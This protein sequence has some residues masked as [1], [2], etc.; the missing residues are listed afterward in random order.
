MARDIKLTIGGVEKDLTLIIQN[1]SKLWKVSEVPRTLARG[2][3]TEVT[4]ASLSAD[5]ELIFEQ[6]DWSG[7][8]GQGNYFDSDR[9]SDGQGIDTTQEGYLMLGPLLN[10]VG[11]GAGDTALD[12]NIGG[13]EFFK[14]NLYCYTIQ[15]IY[16]WDKINGY[17]GAAAAT[18][19]GKTISDLHTFAGYMFV[20][21]GSG[22]N[23]RYTADGAD[24][25]NEIVEY[26]NYFIT[27]PSTD[28]QTSILWKAKT[29]NEVSY[30]DTGL[31]ATWSTVDYIGDTS[32]DITG[33]MIIADNLL[34]GKEDNLYHLDSDERAHPLM[35]ELRLAQSSNNFKYHTM[36]QGS[37][38]F[39][40][41]SRVGEITSRNTIDRVGPLAD[42]TELTKKGS[43][44][45]L[46]SDR[47]WIYCIMDEGANDVVIY[48][49]RERTKRGRLVWEWCPWVYS[50]NHACASIFVCQ[51]SGENARLWFGYG[52]KTAY[53][54]LSDNPLGDTGYSFGTTGYLYTGWYDA[55]FR[56][57]TKLIQSITMENR[58]SMDANVKVTPYYEIDEGSPVQI[59]SAAYIAAAA[60]TKKYLTANVSY[61]K[62]RFKLMLASNA[63]AKTPIVKSF[64][65]S[66][67]LRPEYTKLYDFTVIVGDT[68]SMTSKTIRDF[69]VGGRS[70]TSLVT[71]EDRLGTSHYVVFLPG[72]PE[73]VEILDEVTKQY[74][75][76]MHI[77][78]IEVDWS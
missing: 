61:N 70:S 17:W 74:T 45:G 63:V 28:G 64:T 20:A 42:I 7:G 29:P 8:F 13:F 37:L 30:H 65:A 71:L 62:I 76:A 36:W 4:Y 16:K 55:N 35:N 56:T 14:D 77:M 32:A 25:T 41:G 60:P 59:G 38:Y 34:V 46:A 40:M 10:S 18:F 44:V 75:M 47:D 53:A 48:K 33:L 26:A 24:F 3:V 21:L 12:G 1:K 9:Y 72:Y 31:T 23:Y 2:A 11:I 50:G 6:N 43:C 67:Q 78:A 5:R 57:W 66:G 19:I 68:R 27:A 54:I 39:S 73:E 51:L 15:S 58:G 49:G 52:T 69:L 22:T